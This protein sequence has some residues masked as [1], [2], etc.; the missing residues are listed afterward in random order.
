MPLACT[1]LVTS[2]YLSSSFPNV[3]SRDLSTLAQETQIEMPLRPHS[4]P[5]NRAV[6]MPWHLHPDL[7]QPQ[8]CCSRSDQT[9]TL[10]AST[11][12]TAG[13]SDICDGL[14]RKNKD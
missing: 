13:P 7:Q 1:R 2:E 3:V 6:H 12:F 11:T 8:Q 14:S 10:L 5:L 9:L 4:P